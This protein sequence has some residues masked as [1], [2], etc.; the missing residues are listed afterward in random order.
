MRGLKE[1]FRNG[2][3]IAGFAIGMF[4]VAMMHRALSRPYATGNTFEAVLENEKSDPAPAAASAYARDA[5]PANAAR[6]PILCH[7]Y[8]RPNTTPFEV[9]RILGALFLNLPVLGSMDVWTQTKNEFEKQ[10]TYLYENDYTTIDLDQLAAWRLGRIRLP[11]KSVV[12]TFDDG[13]RSVMEIAYPILK[14]YGMKATLFIVTD[15]VGEDWQ[16]IRG[17]TWDE[18]RTLQQSGVFSIESH[19]SEL[20]YLV[21]TSKGRLPAVVAMSGELHRDYSERS[22]QDA[23][24]EDLVE[25]RRLIAK[26]LSHDSRHLAW[27]YGASTPGTD[28][29]AVLAGFRTLA[30]MR[31]AWSAAPGA[32]AV[33][34]LANATFRVDIMPEVGVY[35]QVA[36]VGSSGFPGMLDL[37]TAWQDSQVDRYAI[38]ART[39]IRGFKQIF[40]P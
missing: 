6:V 28:S 22:W 36:S 21:K 38:T 19:T 7:H 32:A 25:S 29:L 4:V 31:I 1:D 17:L 2:A 14:K 9:V 23:V 26:N 16:G 11:E 40:A 5:G 39:S 33:T 30:G 18:L 34:P 13:D 12:I 35:G 24:V 37:G 15:E 3:I 10:M 20:H 27:P 8:I